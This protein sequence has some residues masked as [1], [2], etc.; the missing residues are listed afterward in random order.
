[1]SV[2]P[3]FDALFEEFVAAHRWTP[4]MATTQEYY[5]Y[6]VP[7]GTAS[8]RV[9][10]LEDEPWY[11]APK[12]EEIVEDPEDWLQRIE[13]ALSELKPATVPFTATAADALSQIPTPNNPF[14]ELMNQHRSEILY[15]VKLPSRA[16]LGSQQPLGGAPD[17]EPVEEQ[18][19][20]P[21]R[22]ENGQMKFLN[23]KDPAAVVDRVRAGLHGLLHGQ[24][25]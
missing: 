10:L 9:E 13:D 20:F 3:I 1:M 11:P 8:D 18:H 7:Y 15:P 22:S 17:S 12:A 19:V 6:D 2:T 25:A 23:L 24:A 5:S 4:M 16:E 14:V 21:I